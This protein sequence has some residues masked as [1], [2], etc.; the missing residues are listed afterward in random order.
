MEIPITDTKFSDRAIR[1]ILVGYSTTGYVLWHP[2]SGKF[3]NSRHVK[4][5]EKV[6]YKNA[7]KKDLHDE[8]KKLQGCESRD[9][10]VDEN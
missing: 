5:N 3:L 9:D 4:F 6:V 2:L 8:I 1:T 10:L 7:Y